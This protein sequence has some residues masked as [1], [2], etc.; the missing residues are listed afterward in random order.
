MAKYADI[1]VD[2]SNG[3]LDKTFQYEI[4]EGLMGRVKI[5]SQVMIP[6]G[7]GN[8][9]IKGFVLG[10]SSEP[11]IAPEKIK[12]I[13]EVP[14]TGKIVESELIELAAFIK[15]SFGSTMNDALKT[16]LPV[17]REIKQKQ[18]RYAAVIVGEA[19]AREALSIARKKKHVQKVRALEYLIERTYP[20]TA[21]KAE[22]GSDNK[23]S[24]KKIDRAQENEAA[25]NKLNGALGRKYIK[26][27]PELDFT[28]S[29]LDSLVKSG[30]IDVRN[31]KVDRLP[32]MPEMVKRDRPVLNEEQQAIV[33]DIYVRMDHND[34]KPSLIYGVTGSGKTEVYLNIIENVISTGKQVIM[35]IPEISLTFQNVNLF[36]MRFKDRVSFMHSKLSLGERSDQARKAEEGSIDIMIGP[37]SALFTPFKN[38]GLIIIDEEQESSYK[39]ENPPKYHAREVAEKRAELAGAMLILGSATPSLESFLRAKQGRY[40]L[41]KLSKRAVEGASLPKVSIVDMRAELRDGNTTMFSRELLND[42]NKTLAEGGQ[43]MLFINRRGYMSCISCRSCG[44]VIKCPHCEVSMTYH[45]NGKLVCHYCGYTIPMPGECPNCKSKLIGGM[46]GGTEKVENSVKK[47]FPDARILRMD[48][49]TTR[50]KDDINNIVSSF[51]KGE[52]DILIG[53]QMI[54]KGHDFKKVRLVGI[55]AAD[56]SLHTSDFRSAE[57]T[58]DLLAQAAGRAGRDK[59]SGKVVIQTYQPEN[60]SIVN[61][62]TE[63]Y[64][65]FFENEIA[66]RKAAQYP[67]VMNMLAVA[68]YSKNEQAASAAVEWLHAIAE[69]AAISG[70]RVYNVGKHTVYKVAD[71]YRKRFFVK[72]TDYEKLADLKD[73]LEKRIIDR[74]GLGSA[75]AQFDFNPLDS[76]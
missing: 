51:S 62:A 18:D 22:A 67:P 50:G 41:Y 58:F 68:C 10:I 36:R 5:G 42:M 21:S 40:K 47:F 48:A 2:I 6:F 63:N 4:P 16:V 25:V 8:R 37:R 74:G 59:A 19:E 54:V 53:T 49:D 55:L 7:N 14:K 75:T 56:I 26:I 38:L 66:F 32:Q 30:I 31:E 34:L 70:I 3:N 44:E 72:C 46:N 45:T 11:K 17:K 1:I 73:I 27:T 39:S 24:S 12:A 15:R 52:A 64:D 57:R 76:Y 43:T 69:E 71:V 35:L 20:N 23:I 33:D 13:A 61:A 29:V 60:Y 65:K 9:K 28:K